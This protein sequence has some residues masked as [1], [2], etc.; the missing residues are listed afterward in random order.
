MHGDTNTC[1]ITWCYLPSQFFREYVIFTVDGS[2]SDEL[3]WRAHNVGSTSLLSCQIIKHS[4]TTTTTICVVCSYR[5]LE[6][7]NAVCGGGGG[8]AGH[9]G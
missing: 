3:G 9:R 2:S 6:R 4:L 1:N 5:A 8:G 7:L